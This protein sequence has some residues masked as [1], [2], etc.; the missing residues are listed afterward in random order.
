[1][2]ANIIREKASYEL[3]DP[4]IFR[5]SFHSNG[6]PSDFSLGICKIETPY[7][8]AVAEAIKY[9]SIDLG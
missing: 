5:S 8:N 3:Q 2:I 6:V 9:F 7:L 4:V 1:M